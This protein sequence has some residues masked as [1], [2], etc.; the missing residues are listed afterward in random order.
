[1][2]AARPADLSN[3]PP[4]FA[5]HWRY[6]TELLNRRLVWLISLLAWPILTITMGVQERLSRAAMGQH[7]TWLDALRFPLVEYLFWALVSPLI[8]DLARKYPLGR[9]HLKRNGVVFLAASL[10]VVATHG[11]YRA[12]LHD[13]VYPI[14]LYPTSMAI[15]TSR[16]EFYVAGN[17]GSDLW[18]F[19]TIVAVAHL[20]LYHQQSRERARELE[21]AQLQV[22]RAQLQ[23]HFFF[24]TLNAITA[25]MH[26]DVDAAD[27]MMV[28]LAA[29]LRRSMRDENE[30]EIPLAEELEILEL[31]TNIERSRF[32]D[33]LHIGV[34]ADPAA[35][36]ALV[37]PF[38]LQPLVENALRHGIALRP[39]PGS[40]EV[41]ASCTADRLHLSVIDDGT[42]F[43]KS[44][45]PGFGVGLSNT[46]ARL[47][48]HYGERHSFELRERSEGGVAA[49]IDIPYRRAEPR[50]S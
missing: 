44:S 35:L 39:G 32:A 5:V 26:E 10:A 2:H 23:P 42:G 25:L 41:R 30:Y 9:Q 6:L 22:L 27:D 40:V 3:S 45:S 20:A 47:Q 29:L 14:A 37:P 38:I 28:N 48:H 43:H 33:R 18:M 7:I 21:R 13:W 19:A 11:I 50:V 36:D 12:P 16:F 46:R 8:F 15:A 17:I 1:M 34:H 49:T 4:P 31:Y 24:N